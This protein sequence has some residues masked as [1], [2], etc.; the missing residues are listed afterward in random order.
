MVIK[1]RLWRLVKKI[2]N[3]NF[4]IFLL[5][6]I[7]ICIAIGSI[8]EQDKS[9]IYY[10]INYP[11]DFN[12]T[13][14][15]NWRLINALGLDHLYSTWWFLFI[16][17][18]LGCSL[19]ICTFSSQLPSLRNARQW[20]FFNYN[21][22]P[23]DTNNTKNLY[24]NS[25]SNLNYSLSMQNYY[26]F[27]KKYSV[28]AYKGLYGRIAP[29]IVH[30]AM[31]ITLF[32]FI[33]SFLSGF[34]VQEMIP[35]GEI[36]HF[37]NVIQSGIQSW[38]PVNLVYKIDAFSITYNKDNSIKQ[39]FSNISIFNNRYQLLTKQMISV[40]HPLKFRNLTFYQTDW[41]INAIR[42]KLSNNILFQRKLF[43]LQM[44]SRSAWLS[45]LPLDSQTFIFIYIINLKD[46]CL[47]FD[48]NGRFICSYNI[49]EKMMFNNNILYINQILS[50]TGLQIKIDNGIVI[51]YL[52]FFILIISTF[53]SYRSYSQ[54]WSNVL[55]DKLYVSGSSN[56][57]VLKFEEDL[58]IIQ[59]M[60]HQYTFVE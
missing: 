19:I 14:I 11:I 27:H 60:Y 46:P 12:H 21:T 29:I 8:I 1:N 58:L 17:I 47:I 53:I 13:F 15:F 48:V 38:A 45:I 50:S 49:G 52:G 40:N 26:I 43:R 9:V 39:F 51:V 4:S 24:K 33:L 57:A 59:Q 30:I 18:I 44:N 32:G 35:N 37:K 31:I 54:I 34:I 25:L 7:A 42:I 5:L 41:N 36:G 10:Q 28:Y 2:A 23:S 16:I 6:I 22:L 20:N 3:L 55:N 56:R